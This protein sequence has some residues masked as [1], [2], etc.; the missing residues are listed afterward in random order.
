MAYKFQDGPFT[1]D[2]PIT[3]ST[4]ITAVEFLGGGAGITGVSAG[5]AG[6][7]TQVQF[8]DGGSNLG[9]DSGLVYNKATDAL[10]VVGAITTTG[11]LS[12][13]G[14]TKL[15]G[16]AQFGSSI[17][18]SGSISSK[19][20]LSGSGD[21]T[22]ATAIDIDGSEVLSKATLGSTVLASSLTSVGTLSSLS[23][24]AITT[25]GALSGSSTT[26]LVGAAQFGSSIAASGS[27]SS[28]GTLSGSGDLTLATAIDI[29]GS[30]VMTKSGLGSTI[31]ASSLTSVGTLTAL[32]VDGTVNLGAGSDT[33]NIGANA[34]DSVTLGHVEGELESAGMHFFEA[35]Q[36]LTSQTVT[37]TT[38]TISVGAMII[39]ASGSAAMNVKLPKIADSNSQEAGNKAYPIYVKRARGEGTIGMQHDITISCSA[40][41]TIDGDTTIVLESANAS[42]LLVGT[43]SVWSVF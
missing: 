18:A 16:A 31:L 25:T 9:G 13:S 8:N 34:S 37:A 21:L 27:I 10:T 1:S 26:K 22:L 17:A 29:D 30:E 4:T 7:D 43:G 42:V 19:G 32:T 36:L 28:K 40:A 35:G 14:I 33:I 24:G 5:A 15:V 3:G 11:A 38:N 39:L 23:V 6:S 12:G 20:T 41:D 2:G